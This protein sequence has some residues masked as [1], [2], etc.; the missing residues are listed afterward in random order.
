MVLG[1]SVVD[2][3][4]RVDYDHLRQERLEK[5]RKQLEEHELGAVLCFDPNNV[6]YITST[7]LG[8]WHRDKMHRYCVLPREGKPMLFDTRTYTLV[9]A[10]RQ[11]VP[12]LEG[13]IRPA[14]TRQRGAI[15][16]ELGRV[17]ECV[18][19]IREMLEEAGVVDEPL[20]VDILDV[21]LMRALETA[22]LKVVDGQQAML[23]ARLIK[24]KDEIELLKIAAMMVDTAFDRVAQAVRPGVQENELSA[25]VYHLLYS[26]GCDQVEAVNVASGPGTN[27]HSS[28]TS[29][30]AIQPGDMLYLDILNC[31]SGYR[32]CVV[33]TFVC[34]KPTEEQKD[35]YRRAYEWLRASIEVVKPGATTADIAKQWPSA[36]EMGMGTEEEAYCLALG[37]AIGFALWEKPIISRLFSLEHPVV[38]QENMVIALETHAGSG[39]NGARIE[40]EVVVTRNGYEVITKYPCD[41]LISC[42]V[43]KYY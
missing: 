4:V 23:D 17:H 29:D 39:V 18:A 28:L 3:E 13:R 9:R 37:H 5:V 10:G 33:R 26:M 30:R 42:W 32:T 36:E 6:R 1:R 7:Q 27:P 43:P 24:T 40:E 34:G 31:Y 35:N 21:P 41:E 2:Y 15:P 22:G 11:L 8:D 20:G 38:L 25:I 14:I 19:G 12:W 16:E